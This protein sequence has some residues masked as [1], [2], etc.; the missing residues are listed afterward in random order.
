[1][2]AGLGF[3]C[4]MASTGREVVCCIFFQTLAPA[5]ATTNNGLRSKPQPIVLNG[6]GD[7]VGT[8]DPLSPKAW[9]QFINPYFN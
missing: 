5:L 8:S 4:L 9:V 1:L 2:L 7:K 6:L 3:S